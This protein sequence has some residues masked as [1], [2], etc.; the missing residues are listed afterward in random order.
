MSFLSATLARVKPSPTIAMNTRSQEL[1]AEGKEVD[2]PVN[3]YN[4]GLFRNFAEILVMPTLKLRAAATGAGKGAS[5]P[6]PEKQKDAKAKK[7]KVKKT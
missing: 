3:S 5:A 7:G 2:R 6:K 4:R 1:K